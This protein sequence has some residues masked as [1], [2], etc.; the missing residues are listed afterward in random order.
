MDR[1]SSRAE[2]PAVIEPA[3]PDDA[4]PVARLHADGI[5]EGF[6]SFLGP[7]F[8]SVLYR[9]MARSSHAVLLV[10]RQDGNVA[11]FVAGAVEPGAFYRSFLL[12]RGPAAA[13]VLA[14]RAVRPSVARRIVE[15][16]RYLRRQSSG[17]HGPELLSIAVGP[18]YLRSGLG[19]R[20]VA[21]LEDELRDQGASRLFV[22][23]G[24]DNAPARRFYER[25][26]FSLDR[27]VEVHP[28]SRSVRYRKSL[29]PARDGTQPGEGPVR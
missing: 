27:D 19:S 12:R 3:R 15:T 2:R 5:R 25:L 9:A 29:E 21:R 8:L 10:A 14:G 23:V 26:G 18:G 17:T 28:G 4:P 16:L 22:V 11:G 24:A 1:A 20:L 7:R 13:L 6:L